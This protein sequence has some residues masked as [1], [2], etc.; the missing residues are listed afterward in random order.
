MKTNKLTSVLGVHAR[1]IERIKKWE[2]QDKK[3]AHNENNK[4][5]KNDNYENQ[6]T[7]ST[8]NQH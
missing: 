1:E 2:I 8:S 4:N 3:C 7:V 6:K 5:S